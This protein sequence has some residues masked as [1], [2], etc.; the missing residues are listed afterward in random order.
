MAAE[1]HVYMMKMLQAGRER[2]RR[3]RRVQG[4][5]T[6]R[7]GE[8]VFCAAAPAERAQRCTRCAQQCTC[9]EK[10]TPSG[11]TSEIRLDLS[12]L[13]PDVERAG[14]SRRAC[15]RLNVAD[16]GCTR[17]CSELRNLTWAQ[18]ESPIQTARS[19]EKCRPRTTARRGTRRGS[20]LVDATQHLHTV[21]GRVRRTEHAGLA[22]TSGRRERSVDRG[23]GRHVRADRDSRARRAVRRGASRR[24]AS[25]RGEGQRRRRRR[26]GLDEKEKAYSVAEERL[27]LS[28]DGGTKKVWRSTSTCTI[29][30]T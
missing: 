30:Q 1:I 9:D 18:G 24:A 23:D 19:G 8:S 20:A 7:E 22:V 14:S 4:R 13:E 27:V 5:T 28:I 12:R 11:R 26:G 21:E 15:E 17:I 29:D 16:G 3:A 2:D 6:E 25:K 10:T